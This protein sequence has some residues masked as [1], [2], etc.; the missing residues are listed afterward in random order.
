MDEL[1]TT[2]QAKFGH[3]FTLE[4]KILMIDSHAAGSNEIKT[5]KNL[6][7]QRK[8]QMIEVGTHLR[9]KIL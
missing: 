2:V 6:L 9:H 4:D 8:Q 5:L 1:N 3:I 7:A